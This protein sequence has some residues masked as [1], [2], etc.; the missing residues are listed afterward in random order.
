M[1]YIGY[2]SVTLT[3]TK[4]DADLNN[5]NGFVCMLTLTDFCPDGTSSSSRFRY[6]SQC[7][8][9]F[10]LAEIETKVDGIGFYD[11]ARKWLL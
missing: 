2:G 9:V 6:Q 8:G 10:T 11:N 5:L 4:T 1:I 7:Y 3:D